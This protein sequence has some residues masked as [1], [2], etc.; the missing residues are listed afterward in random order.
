MHRL[1][2]QLQQLATYLRPTR[3][4]STKDW[5]ENNIDLSYDVTANG[6]GLVKLRPYQLAIAE[7]NDDPKVRQITL[8]AGERLGKSFIWKAS[9]L[10]AMDIDPV[11]I[12][13][14]YTSDDECKATN[15]D[16]FLPLMDGIPKLKEE[17]DRPRSKRLDSFHFRDCIMYF[18]GSGSPI[19]SKTA[20]IGVADELDFWLALPGSTV[21]QKKGKIGVQ[22]GKNVH[23]FDNLK[24]RLMNYPERSKLWAVSSPTTKAGRTYKEFLKGSQSYWGLRCQNNKC[25]NLIPTH[26]MNN[27]QFD[28]NDDGD[29]TEKSIRL[30]CPKCKYQHKEQQAIKMNA[31]GGYIVYK[32][33]RYYHKSYQVGAL[34][35]PRIWKWRVV[36]EAIRDASKNKADV[37]AQKFLDQ[38]VRGMPFIRRKHDKKDIE[39]IFKKHQYIY[40]DNI[41]ERI[42]GLFIALDSQVNGSYYVIKAVDSN[43]NFYHIENGFIADVNYMPDWGRLEE[44]TSKLYYGKRILAGIIDTGTGEGRH[45]GIQRFIETH[46]G[47]CGYKGNTKVKYDDKNGLK[48]KQSDTTINLLLAHPYAYQE[49]LLYLLYE[50]LSPKN[51]NFFYLP[52]TEEIDKEYYSHLASVRPTS[53]AGG[54]EYQNWRSPKDSPDHYFDCEKMALVIFDY[55]CEESTVS[56]NMWYCNGLPPFIVEEEI[57]RYKAEVQRNKLK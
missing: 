30:V 26:S 34:A 55:W 52:K 33:D 1:K 43:R 32:K 41:K 19:V 14:C 48:Y 15:E 35:N 17:K 3:L 39:D 57:R 31:N 16:T 23:N 29:I 11:P 5:V 20:C 18:Q 21:D 7:A 51:D 12:I 38:T 50:M 24:K 6:T 56:N 46:Q 22:E 2:Q 13:A 45:S 28:T 10:R 44:I 42:I 40:P 53:R 25:K 4:I 9:V 37:L 47:W 54:D 36:C 8:M 27:L 49:K